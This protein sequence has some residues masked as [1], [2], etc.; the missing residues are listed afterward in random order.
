MTARP[1]TTDERMAADA[2][3]TAET[4]ARSI[5]DAAWR[6]VQGS[7]AAGELGAGE[8]VIP[9]IGQE[10]IA[11]R[12]RAARALRERI[13]SVDV[14]SLPATVALDLAAAAAMAERWDVD[15]DAY[16][17]MFDPM[18]IGFPSMFAPSAYAGGYLLNVVHET[19]SRASVDG[20]EGVA[21]HLRLLDGYGRLVRQLAERTTG[22]AERGIVLPAQQLAAAT[23]LVRGLHATGR[24][25]LRGVVDRSPSLTDGATT[26]I[27][28]RTAIAVD[29]AFEALL[30]VLG[31][32]E[33]VARASDRVGL[34]QHPGGRDAYERVVR[35][36]TTQDLSAEQV[37]AR[38]HERMARILSEMRT[39]MAG[40]DF[41]GTPQQYLAALADDPAWRGD[42]AASIAAHFERA[43]E[44]LEP[45]LA[46]QFGRL[47]SAPYGVDAVPDAVAGS[48]TFGYYAPPQ[49]GRETGL[50]LFNARNLATTALPHIPALTYHELMP[51]HHLAVTAQ[52]EATDRHPL[53]QHVSLSAYGEGWAEYAARLAGEIGMYRTPQERFGRLMMDAFLTSRLVVD[54]G[55]N[56]LGWDLERA[57][58]YMREHAFLG[59]AEVDSETLRYSC[60][61]PGQA[62]AYKLG[63]DFLFDLR[64]RMRAS[65]GDAFD[66]VAFH[67]AV[68][69]AAGLPLPFVAEHVA[70]ELGA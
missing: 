2:A 55:L 38:G 15:D 26:R 45:H 41:A 12:A 57:R 11:R 21:Q 63:D 51:G 42:D 54:T 39:L 36:H 64:E 23:A 4:E 44:R 59:D 25:V 27:E 31:D 28:E 22:Q 50:Y 7:D 10:A 30:A 61:I 65:L 19:L 62:L 47:P 14:D 37:H 56:A 60:D 53:G 5:V 24:A 20:D 58:A 67:D 16:W 70:R 66:V 6:I 68:L 43:I 9:D 52:R 69:G 48:M 1:A 34:G 32:D 46:A 40:E 8:I 49:P 18:G 3:A 29:G 17:L 33:L 35:L 13:A